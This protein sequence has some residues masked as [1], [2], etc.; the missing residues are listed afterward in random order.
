M[1]FI[2]PDSPVFVNAVQRRATPW[3]AQLAGDPLGSWLSITKV[4]VS[5]GQA[6]AYFVTLKCWAQMDG[7]SCF[8]F[9]VTKHIQMKKGKKKRYATESKKRCRTSH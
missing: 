1:A 7:L 3:W 2:K 4:R 6:Q 8:V 9:V 5:N